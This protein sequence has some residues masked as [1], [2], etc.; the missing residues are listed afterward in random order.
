MG[1]IARRATLRGAAIT[2]AFIAVMLVLNL[3]GRFGEDDSV[4]SLPPIRPAAGELWSVAG[5]LLLV[6]LLVSL[7]SGIWMARRRRS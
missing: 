2:L 7:L 3:L 1:S 5:V 4:S 6:F